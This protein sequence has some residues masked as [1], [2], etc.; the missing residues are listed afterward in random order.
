MFVG[1]GKREEGDIFMMAIIIHSIIF[2]YF[3]R[4]SGMREEKLN[5]DGNDIEK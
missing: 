5:T 2:Q 4:P 3:K 1:Y